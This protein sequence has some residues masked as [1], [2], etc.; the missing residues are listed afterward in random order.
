VA[1]K[2]IELSPAWQACLEMAWEAYTCDCV[3]VGAVVIDGAGQIV[4]RGRNRLREQAAP[5]RQVCDSQL[6]HAELN[7]LLELKVGS[8]EVH[9]YALYTSLEPCP[10]CMGA[11]YMSGARTLYYASPDT[12]AGSTDLLG[13]TPYLAHK[14]IRVFGPFYGGLAEFGCA[15]HV[16][17][18]RRLARPGPM[19]RD[20]VIEANRLT[21]PRGVEL[22]EKLFTSGA[23][24]GWARA[25]L[26]I[27]TVFDLFQEQ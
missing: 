17:F 25:G 15:L 1:L 2:W 27:G 4:S 18:I 19:D 13:K 11:F 24:Q 14:P 22:G 7:A 3:P 5:P 16:D 12:Y 8:P 9:D 20:A 23:A 21:F 26:E 6:A 10:L